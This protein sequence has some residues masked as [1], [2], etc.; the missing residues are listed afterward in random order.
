MSLVIYPNFTPRLKENPFVELYRK[1]YIRRSIENLLKL[2]EE[3]RDGIKCNLQR[4]YEVAGE[5]T[6]NVIEIKCVDYTTFPISEVTIPIIWEQELDE[7]CDT[8]VIQRVKKFLRTKSLE[9]FADVVFTWISTENCKSKRLWEIM[10]SLGLDKLFTFDQVQ[11][12]FIP[13]LLSYPFRP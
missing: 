1:D 12:L 8:R 4:G 2:A 6:A 11:K 5:Y 7:V 9:D 10:T 3:K 13:D